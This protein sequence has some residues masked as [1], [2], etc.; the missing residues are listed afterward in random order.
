MTAQRPPHPRPFSRRAAR[1]GAVAAAALVLTTGLT[2]CEDPAGDDASEGGKKGGKEEAVTASATFTEQKLSWKACPAPTPLQGTGAE[3]KP[4][5][6]GTR[7]ECAD[8]KAPLDWA[9]QDGKTID[10]ALVRAKAKDSGRRLG[11]LVYNFGGPGASGVAM[12]PTMAKDSYMKL[13]GRYDLVSFDPRSIGE[14]E[15]VRCLDD[16]AT[17][18]GGDVDTSP[19]TPA[20]VE[21]FSAHLRKTADACRRNSGAILPHADTKSTARDM[22]RHP[23][24]GRRADGPEPRQGRGHQHRQPG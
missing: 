23:V 8:M 2:A 4:L 17:D 12:L 11:S 5:P 19:E 20:E 10:I 22:D 3:P 6:D 14:S 21:Q 1:V 7:W 9:K 24:R 16:R 13:H 18:A 15:G